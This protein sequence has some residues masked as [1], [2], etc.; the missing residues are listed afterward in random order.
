VA[1]NERITKKID[2]RNFHENMSRKSK[3]GNDRTKIL[4]T[5]HKVKITLSFVAGDINLPRNH[6][7]ATISILTLLPV[8]LSSTTHTES[9]A[10]S[11]PQQWLRER[12]KLLRLTLYRGADKSLA[13]P[14]YFPTYFV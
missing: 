13:R 12:A 10:A 7:Q 11:P 2:T 1:H 14:T 6:C 4:G 8:T 5:L 9:T 3:F